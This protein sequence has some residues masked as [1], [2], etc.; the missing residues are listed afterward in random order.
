MPVHTT[1]VELL[2]DEDRILLKDLRILQVN[3]K[4]NV[5][6]GNVNIRWYQVASGERGALEV[7]V[8][9]PVKIVC[10]NSCHIDK[11]LESLL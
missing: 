9:S 5:T 7:P 4:P 10:H 8:G 6:Q 11:E 3:G 1:R 2:R